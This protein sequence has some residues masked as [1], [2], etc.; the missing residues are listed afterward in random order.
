MCVF[1]HSQLVDVESNDKAMIFTRFGVVRNVK[2]WN[3]HCHSC[4]FDD[5]HSNMDSGESAK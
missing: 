2:I 1:C 4:K 5:W 3:K